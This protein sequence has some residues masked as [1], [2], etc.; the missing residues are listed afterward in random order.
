MR[1]II[2]GGGTGGHLF[3]GIAIAEEL[4]GRDTGNEILFVGTERGIEAR[5]LPGLGWHVRFISA[6]GIKG[7]GTSSRIRA[8]FKLVPG[9]FESLKVIRGFK[10]DV[11]IGVGGYASAPLLTAA[12]VLGI[13]TAIHEQNALPGMTNRLL[14]K[15]V[16]RVFVSFPGSST[17]FPGRKVKV[18]GN[19][20]RK[21]IFEGLKEPSPQPSPKGRG[22]TVLIFGG[23]LGAHRINTAALEM[24]RLL[25]RPEG[26]RIIHQT[27][28]R[29]LEEVRE[30]YRKAG[31]DADIRP[32]IDDMAS[33]YR[34]A[35]LVICRAGATTIAEL[36]VVGK[37]SILIPYPF[38]ADDHQRVN[39]EVLVK[40]GGAL[41]VLEK[42]LTGERLASEVKRLLGDRE[43]L[44]VMGDGARRLARVDAARVVVDGLY[45]LAKS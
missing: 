24:I 42:E 38:A 27:G 31:W 9:I 28:E 21:G 29:D 36:T 6:E 33:A 32:F 43:M 14:G 39:A 35:D 10:P 41:M 22:R 16:D 4:K 20:L 19:P 2:A 17:F 34:D 8:V 15:F 13:K 7:R 11:V 45:E 40:T 1:V 23:S 18:S 25:S 5:L 37:P 3:P 30:G 26:W 12:R 44:K